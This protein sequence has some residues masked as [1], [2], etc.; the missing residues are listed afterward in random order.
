MLFQKIMNCNVFALLVALV[1][2]GGA[3]ARTVE[4]D[5]TITEQ[6]LAPAGKN[7]RVLAINGGIPG[8]T[9]RFTEGDEA[10]IRVHNQLSREET[11]THWHGLLVPNAMDGVPYTT[12]PPIKPG[13]S[14]TFKFPLRQSGTY[15]YHS[16]TGLQEQRGIFGSIVVL[17]KGG[18][19]VKTSHDHVLVL[20][21]WTN[22]NPNVIMRSLMSGYD[23]DAIKKG[24]KQSILGATKAG[25]LGEYFQREWERIPPMDLSD[26]YFD[27]FFINGKTTSTIAGKPGEKVRL[28]LINAAAASYFYVNNSAGPMTI[29][30]A[31]G[32][33]VQPV[34]VNE[35]LMG[36][37]ETYDVIIT[38]PPS[39]SY[40][41]RATAQDGSGHASVWI[42]S[43]TPHS[44]PE[45]P[46]ANLYKMDYMLAG[47]FEALGDAP[48]DGRPLPPYRKLRAPQSTVLPANAPRREMTLRLTGDMERYIWS[49]NNKTLTEESTIRVKKGEVLTFQLVNDTMMHHPIHLHGHFFRLINGQGER[50]PLKHTVDVPP[51]GKRTIE[52]EA[53]DAGDWFFHCHLL[54]HM[55]AGMARVITY[56]QDESYKPGLDPALLD[57]Y[58]WM[59]MGYVQNNM[60]MGMAKIMNSRNDFGIEWDVGHED[61]MGGKHSLPYEI[62][63]TWGRYFNP[64][65]LTLLGGRFTN[66]DD[67]ES[68]AIAG[69]RYRMPGFVRSTFTIDSEGDARVEL[70]KSFQ[71]TE[72]LSL[73]GGIE[74]DT[75]SEWRSTIGAEYILMRNFSAVTS[76]DS[77]HGFGAGIGFRF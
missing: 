63:A 4:Y 3:A 12:T 38:V 75:G 65:F 45:I 30:A 13:Q 57:P 49:F 73:F 76:Y 1:V 5:L 67:F 17:P 35:L 25:A 28:R 77:D 32:P 43:G 70:A 22:R 69:F 16:H 34:K 36:I 42:G 6:T 21:D 29:V 24:N 15:W 74:Y 2:G 33:P 9:L 7:V 50:S 20:S 18:E 11:S 47:A 56:N 52:F 8:P 26:V 51:M 54:Y 72:R 59:A 53:N 10:V 39:G 40:E 14:Y 61:D 58:Y 37:A 19:P 31:D 64:N 27:A 62:D 23:Y 44:A 55:E 41:I 71:L 66:E 68:R 46:K 60:S 48:S